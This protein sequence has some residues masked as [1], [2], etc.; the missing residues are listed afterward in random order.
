MNL[1]PLDCPPVLLVIFN[2]PDLTAKS[3]ASI[4]RAKPSQLFIAA[5]GPRAGR[6]GEPEL[7]Q[8]ARRVVEQVDWTC[9]LKTLFRERNVGC[10][11]GVSQSI[12]WFF[13]HVE[14]GIILEDDCIA[15][16]SFF[17][18]CAELLD[19]YRAESD[20]LSISGDNNQGG[21]I[22]GRGSYFFSD[23]Q[24]I[25]GW[26]TWRRAWQHYSDNAV[27]LA[28][29][30]ASGVIQRKFGEH[31]AN[32]WFEKFADT[33]AGRIDSWAYLWLMSCWAVN[34]VAILPNVNLVTNVGFDE[35]ASHTTDP[36]N[37]EAAM[38]TAPIPFPLKHS[39]KLVAC[40]AAD[41][42]TLREVYGIRRPPGIFRRVIN[43][44]KRE[45]S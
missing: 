13:E 23:F 5:D 29:L 24:Q 14:A 2:R 17:P 20:V 45:L 8:Q 40:R 31:A 35:R 21:R 7:C 9:Q 43:R 38:P 37:K 3:F 30:K 12:S 27:T 28:Q 1:I 26:A 10:R 42:Y 41:R 25:W 33:L 22:R 16:D 6:T 11:R 44:I 34:G 36:T 39:E 4:R 19:R 18:Y 32:V 15:E